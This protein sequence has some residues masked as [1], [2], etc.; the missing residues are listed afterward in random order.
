MQSVKRE[1]GDGNNMEANSQWKLIEK[2]NLLTWLHYS[3]FYI[4]RLSFKTNY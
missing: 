3:K 4:S 2:W 1:V